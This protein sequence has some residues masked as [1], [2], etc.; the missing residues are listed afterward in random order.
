MINRRTFFKRLAMVIGA[1]CVAPTKALAAL[2]PADVT[3]IFSLQPIIESGGQALPPPTLFVNPAVGPHL[4]KI[5][6]YGLQEDQWFTVLKKQMQ[7]TIDNAIMQ[8]YAKVD[9]HPLGDWHG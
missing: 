8:S 6:E 4:L 5:Q 9:V 1:V 3:N 2:V 7:H